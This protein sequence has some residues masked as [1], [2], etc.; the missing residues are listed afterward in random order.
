MNDESL[1]PINALPRLTLREKAF[2]KYE[3][4]IAR[5]L[6]ESY[7]LDPFAEMNLRAHSFVLGFKDATLGFK[8]YGYDSILIPKGADFRVLRLYELSDD[9]VSIVNLRAAA[10]EARPSIPSA[11]KDFAF[12]TEIARQYHMH[13][14]E[15]E[16][17]VSFSTQEGMQRVL[18]LKEP[19][20]E[21]DITCKKHSEGLIVLRQ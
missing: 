10:V 7:T 14:R 17:F 8:R 19:V 3:R 12:I 15:D 18:D 4:Y 2:R 16:T 21:Y 11:E 20:G 6:K 5:A 9:S 1:A 13:E